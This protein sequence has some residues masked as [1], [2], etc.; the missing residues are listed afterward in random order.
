MTRTAD[1]HGKVVGQPPRGYPTTFPLQVE[2]IGRGV[3]AEVAISV[4]FRESSATSRIRGFM[5][6]HKLPSLT[7][8][9]LAHVAHFYALSDRLLQ[10]TSN[11]VGRRLGEYVSLGNLA[12]Q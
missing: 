1:F 7:H 2:D 3:V 4:G 8:C 5:K 12:S 9:N 10:V 11:L 6:R